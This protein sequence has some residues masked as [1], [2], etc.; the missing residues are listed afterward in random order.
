MN[1][2]RVSDTQLTAKEAVVR[3]RFVVIQDETVKRGEDGGDELHE[4]VDADRS[5]KRQR[6]VQLGDRAQSWELLERKLG[7]IVAQVKRKGQL[8]QSGQF[9]DLLQNHQ[10]RQ[11]WGVDAFR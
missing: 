8:L 4:V 9:G 7:R 3:K 6:N 5:G 10:K 2:A 1:G 11:L